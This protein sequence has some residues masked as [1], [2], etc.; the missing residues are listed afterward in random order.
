MYPAVCCGLQVLE[1]VGT[2]TL[3]DSLQCVSAGGSVCMTGMVGNMWTLEDFSP[4]GC[5]PHAV[6]LTTYSGGP[7]DFK[8]TPLEDLVRQIAG[9]RLKVPVSARKFQDNSLSLAIPTYL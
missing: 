4:M 2:T 7:E 1:L 6:N 3:L 5:I 8:A 9:G